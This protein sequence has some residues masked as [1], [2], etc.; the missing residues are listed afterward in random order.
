MT[1]F[2]VVDDSAVDRRLVGGLLE[3]GFV[4]TVEYA[5]N[6]AEALARLESAPPQVVVTDLTMPIMD[7]LALV[8][9]MRR[10]FPEIPAI[11]MTAYGSEAVALAALEAGAL[12]YVPKSQLGAKLK[13]RVDDVL[14]VARANRGY[15]QLLGCLAE[16]R[17]HFVLDNDATLID[18]LLD[19]VGQI[20]EGTGLC[21][22]M[23]R[24]QMQIA[25]RE[26]L[27]NAMFH[28]N[29]EM[30]F[31]AGAG[32][33]EDELIGDDDLSA[34]DRRRMEPPY[35]ERRVDVRVRILPDEARLTIRDQ[36][37]GFDHRA[38]L[39]DG[40]LDALA[41]DRGRGLLMMRTFMDEVVFNEAGNE[42]TMVKRRPPAE[43]SSAAPAP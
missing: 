2:L 43:P 25:A 30:G 41:S 7:G 1:R 10:R 15:R 16:T 4:C 11:L 38:L 12:G 34:M 36:G 32:A 27:L 26:A 37:A 35:R 42:V 39:P 24:L 29:L 28:G 20:A 31:E 3:Q 23:G 19:M 13:K 22:F 17:F 33:E 8:T 40:D 6:G 21:D 9:A 5:A 18:P 14:A